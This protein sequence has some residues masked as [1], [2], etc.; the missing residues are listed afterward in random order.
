MCTT[1]RKEMV[2]G[3]GRESYCLKC[4]PLGS[5]EPLEVFKLE[6]DG[7]IPLVNNKK[8]SHVGGSEETDFPVPD[9]T[10]EPGLG[11]RW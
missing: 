7:I 1:E 3:V 2:W 6:V 10:A 9:G 8:L 4:H 5:M 11:S